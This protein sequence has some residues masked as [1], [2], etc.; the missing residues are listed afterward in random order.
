MSHQKDFLE[1][2]AEFDNDLPHVR[3]KI[4]NTKWAYASQNHEQLGTRPGTD[5]LRHPAKKGQ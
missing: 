1:A 3:N 4:E 5:I 2:S